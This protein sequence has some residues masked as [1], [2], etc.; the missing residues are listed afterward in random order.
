VYGG[1]V[2]LFGSVANSQQGESV[3]ISEQPI[4]S[5]SGVRTVATVQT[6]TDGSFSAVVRPLIRTLYRASSGQAT[7]NAIA[8]NV[9]PRLTLTRIGSHRFALKALSARSFTGRYGVLQR[10][11]VRTHR[12]IGVRRVFFT[13][14]FPGVS[15]TITSRASFRARFGGARIRVFVPRSQLSPGYV[16]GVSNVASA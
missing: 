2:N 8:I 15:P 7:S 12:W 10:F 16:S 9:R 3:S 4:P 11:S 5:F 14:A 6:A 1:T 13:R